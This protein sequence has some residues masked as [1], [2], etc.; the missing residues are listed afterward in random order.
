MPTL[1]FGCICTRYMHVMLMSVWG[2]NVMTHSVSRS[3]RIYHLS[4][5]ILL[6]CRAE[7][8]GNQALLGVI[9]H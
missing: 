1:G 9:R 8:C 5:D 7:L 2:I 6:V 3:L 4:E